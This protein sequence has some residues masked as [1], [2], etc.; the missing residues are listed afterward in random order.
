MVQRHDELEGFHHLKRGSSRSQLSWSRQCVVG[1]V[2]KVQM[3][4][5]MEQLQQLEAEGE[6]RALW[7]V[8]LQQ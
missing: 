1:V 5:P 3:A 7:M 2:A 4:L 6:L 8:Q